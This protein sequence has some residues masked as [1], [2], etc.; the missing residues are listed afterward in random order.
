MC[1]RARISAKIFSLEESR[2]FLLELL[3]TVGFISSYF[4]LISEKLS[5]VS[6]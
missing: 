2:F 5:L 6:L 4:V 1:G 3:C